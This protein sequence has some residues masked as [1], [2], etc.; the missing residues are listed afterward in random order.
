MSKSAITF[1]PILTHSDAEF[2]LGDKVVINTATNK[3]TG[4][5][6]ELTPIENDGIITIDNSIS[7]LLSSVIYVGLVKD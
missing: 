3:V 7:I 1:K 2:N 4:V 5:V 6:T